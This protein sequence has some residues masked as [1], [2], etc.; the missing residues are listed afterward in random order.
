MTKTFRW[1]T[2]RGSPATAHTLE[3]GGPPI[4]TCGVTT[5]PAELS[6]HTSGDRD[7]V[8]LE[9]ADT[10]A[11]DA[12]SGPPAKPHTRGMARPWPDE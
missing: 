3:V 1:M 7:W 2:R 5:L 8:C 9:C 4:C 6:A 10:D 11:F 12:E